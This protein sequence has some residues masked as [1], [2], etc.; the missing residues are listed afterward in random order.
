MLV[1]M[2]TCIF[3]RHRALLEAKCHSPVALPIRSSGSFPAGALPLFPSDRR[4][5]APA[6]AEIIEALF[7]L[8]HWPPLP[9][10]PCKR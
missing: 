3:A 6:P 5:A 1:P 8:V 10:R 2:T 7:E 4:S 9:A